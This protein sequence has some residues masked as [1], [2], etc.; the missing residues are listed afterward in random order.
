MAK[1]IKET[2][3]LMGKD[4]TRFTEEA[5]ANETKRISESDYRKMLTNYKLIKG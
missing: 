4:A 1:P 3:V 2:P 5:K